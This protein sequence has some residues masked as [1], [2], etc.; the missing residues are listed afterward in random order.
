MNQFSLG[1]DELLKRKEELEKALKAAQVT[2][3][4]MDGKMQ[5]RYDTQKEEWALQCDI[6][7]SQIGQ[8]DKLLAELQ[9]LKE[10]PVVPTQ[11]T[12]V[13]G[14]QVELRVNSN[15]LENYILLDESG[16]Y[17]LKGVATLSTKSPIGKAILGAKAGD[18]VIIDVRG[19]KTKVQI[20]RLNSQ[21]KP[22]S[23]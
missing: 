1:V 22:S 6:Y 3:D 11:E 4:Q 23:E 18:T 21:A 19:V 12:V 13:V 15:E 2:R 20:V 17:R 14:S 9:K 7:E 16:G 5:S 8:I 10:K